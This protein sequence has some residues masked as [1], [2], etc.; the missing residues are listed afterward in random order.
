MKRLADALFHRR[1]ILRHGVR[2]IPP[3]HTEFYM[4]HAET[5][6]SEHS[7]RRDVGIQEMYPMTGGAHILPQEFL[8]ALHALFVLHLHERILNGIID[9][10]EVDKGHLTRLAD[11]LIW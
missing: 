8:H 10:I 6:A 1:H 2:H 5:S 9:R 4:Y 3:P 7:Q 11:L